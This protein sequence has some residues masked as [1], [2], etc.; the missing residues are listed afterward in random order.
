MRVRIVSLIIRF[1]IFSVGA[2]KKMKNCLFV[3]FQQSQGLKTQKHTK[4][5]S[6]LWPQRGKSRLAQK[7]RNVSGKPYLMQ[8][9]KKF[10]KFNH[11]MIGITQI[12]VLF[13]VQSYFQGIGFFKNKSMSIAACFLLAINFTIYSLPFKW[14]ISFCAMR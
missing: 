11:G 13:T 5:E 3:F 10:Q 2:I 8:K 7:T 9:I 6:F 14:E 1:Q 12:N 4:R